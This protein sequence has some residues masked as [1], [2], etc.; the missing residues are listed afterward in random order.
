MK[1]TQIFTVALCAIL[2]IGGTPLS[3]HAAGITMVTIDPEVAALKMQ[4]ATLQVKLATLQGMESGMLDDR[5]NLSFKGTRLLKSEIDTED[6]IQ[7]VNFYVKN[8]RY[9]GDE[10][11][12]LLFDYE[13]ELYEVVDN[14]RSKLNDVFQGYALIPS[15]ELNSSFRV[16]IENGRYRGEDN[17]TFIA[18]IRIDA[19]RLIKESNESDNVKWSNE[20]TVKGK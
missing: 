19:G 17:R 6:E 12:E 10:L 2:V 20:W 13:V 14:K 7:R 8:N 3:A 15:A 16:E 11:S 18:K 1:K 5:Q 4:L 9:G